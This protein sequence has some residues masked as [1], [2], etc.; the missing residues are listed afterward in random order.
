MVHFSHIIYSSCWTFPMS[1]R[2]TDPVWSG[3]LVSD[4]S[5]VGD[6]VL[7]RMKNQNYSIKM[8]K[9]HAILFRIELGTRRWMF[10]FARINSSIVFH[11][12]ICKIKITDFAKNDLWSLITRHVP[13]SQRPFSLNPDP[14]KNMEI[15][16]FISVVTYCIYI[17]LLHP[18]QFCPLPHRNSKKSVKDPVRI[19]ESRIQDPKGFL[20]IF[21]GSNHSIKQN[22]SHISIMARAIRRN[23]RKCRSTSGSVGIDV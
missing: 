6:A 4:L 21:M 16:S 3:S 1:I 18:T 10:N 23:T 14:D 5:G 15:A 8:P 22:P 19:P 2:V 7:F 13:G 12:W 17:G 11:T 20:P 9:Q